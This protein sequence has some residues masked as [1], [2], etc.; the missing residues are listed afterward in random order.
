MSVDVFGRAFGV[1]RSGGGGKRGPPGPPGEGFK[2]TIAGHYDL[3]HKKLCNVG[4]AE[5]DFDAVSLK[6]LKAHVDKLRGYMFDIKR[7]LDVL[8]NQFTTFQTAYSEQQEVR[9]RTIEEQLKQLTTNKT[10]DGI[11]E[12]DNSRRAS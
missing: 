12:E 4:D 2:R 1:A 8:Q 3:E 5:E 7:G 10:D 6:I 11:A 9:R